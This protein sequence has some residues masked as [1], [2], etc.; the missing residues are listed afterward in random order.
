MNIFTK[1][2]RFYMNA[3]A[4]HGQ[5]SF[6]DYF[7]DI[8]KA[9]IRVYFNEIIEKEDDE[10]F[11]SIFSRMRLLFPLSAGC[12]KRRAVRQKSLFG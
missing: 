6:R 2:R 12:V 1:N 3:L 7:K 9:V 5:D 8:L 4:V 11:S 10:T